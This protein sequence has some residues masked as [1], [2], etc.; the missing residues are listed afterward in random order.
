MIKN[1][2]SA[3]VKINIS[4]MFIPHDLKSTMTNIIFSILDIF[5]VKELLNQK[6]YV[7]LK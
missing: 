5:I 7:F 2:R 4:L 1:D 6:N 3:S